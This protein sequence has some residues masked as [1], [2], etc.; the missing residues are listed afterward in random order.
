MI[1]LHVIGSKSEATDAAYLRGIPC[2]FVSCTER[3]DSASTILHVPVQFRDAL[4]AWLAEPVKRDADCRL[5]VGTLF[6]LHATREA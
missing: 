6:S 1:R 4:F 5:P 3:D 2:E